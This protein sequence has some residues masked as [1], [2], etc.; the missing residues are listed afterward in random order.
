MAHQAT[1]V[2]QLRCL[3]TGVAV[4]VSGVVRISKGGS[5]SYALLGDG[6]D[7]RQ[8]EENEYLYFVQADGGVKVF[9][10]GE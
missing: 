3:D 10:R 4:D 1:L 7:E 8:W 5:T 6:E 2:V 9:G